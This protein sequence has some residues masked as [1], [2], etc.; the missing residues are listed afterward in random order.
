[1]VA[2][3]TIG[4]VV[5]GDISSGDEK[6]LIFNCAWWMKKQGLAEQ[7]IE[8][9]TKILRILAKR[10]VNLHDP[11]SVKD[12]IARQKW[13]AG[14]K[15]NAVL[16]Y[17]TLLKM[18]GKTWTPPRYRRIEKDPWIPTESEVDQLIAGS[19]TKVSTF[20]Q[21]LKETGMR[22][23]EAWSLK[24]TDINTENSTVRITPEKGSNPR[25]LKL[26]SRLL[27]MMNKLERGK[28]YVFNN[29]LLDHFAQNFRQQRKAV[30][31]KLNNSRINQINFKTLRHFKATMEYHK[32]KDILHVKYLLGHKRIENT[33]IY[34]HLVDFG[35]DEYVSKVAKNATEACQLV[36]AGFDFVCSTPD[37][38]I[39][40]RKRK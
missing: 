10:G 20:L 25:T 18:L 33:L 34:T 17:T 11:E 22:P 38:L 23:G 27:S 15:E 9:R 28:I 8:S 6:E 36:E 3:E 1:M 5:A 16:S 14:R 24:W 37:G 30:A 2:T 32:T 40:F 31:W 29:G 21:L 35:N 4:N 39:V 19:S 13:C 26:S 7:T 12:G